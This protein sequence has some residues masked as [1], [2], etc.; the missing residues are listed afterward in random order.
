MI[1]FLIMAFAAATF[2]SCTS[3]GTKAEAEQTTATAQQESDKKMLAG[4]YGNERAVSAE[5][6]AFF[7]EMTSALKGVVYTP[8]N[9]AT[10]VVAGKNYRFVCKAETVAAEP[11]TYQVEII[12]Y[13]PL[14][15]H[16]EP[17]ITSLKRL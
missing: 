17:M 4:G 8:E 5:E 3:S 2:T 10:Q 13:Q 1:K 15:N 9:V 7:N 6:L 14:P 11:K 16:G 12:I